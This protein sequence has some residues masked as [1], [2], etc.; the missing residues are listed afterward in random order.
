[1]VGLLAIGRLDGN[2]PVVTDRHIPIR[3]MMLQYNFVH[4]RA[5]GLAQLN[6][7]FWNQFVSSIVRPPATSWP[8]A[9][10]DLPLR[11]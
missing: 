11:R 6:N 5:G 2:L 10:T 8:K 4:N 7:G 3:N 9:P 1:M